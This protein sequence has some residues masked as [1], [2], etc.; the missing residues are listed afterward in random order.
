ML[1]LT[2]RQRELLE[3]FDRAEGGKPSSPES[4]LNICSI[5]YCSMTARCTAS[6]AE[7]RR[8]RSS[9]SSC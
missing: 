3:E 1:P 9:L 4:K 7:T 5:P 2:K 8:F 6:R